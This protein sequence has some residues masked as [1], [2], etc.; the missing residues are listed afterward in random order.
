MKMNHRYILFLLAIIGLPLSI[1]ATAA[2]T[3]LTAITSEPMPVANLAWSNDGQTL[4]FQDRC[5]GYTGVTLAEQGWY[6]YDV[7]TQT[8][9]SGYNW[10][11]APQFTQSEITSAHI[12]NSFFNFAS[13]QGRYAAYSANLPDVEFPFY[14]YDRQENESVSLLYNYVARK[15]GTDWFNM[16]WSEDETAFVAK[17]ANYASYE[18]IADYYYVSNYDSALENAEFT[19]L[20]ETMIDEGK[21]WLDTIYDISPN[22]QYVL[23][24]GAE[25]EVVGGILLYYSPQ[26]PSMDNVI[27]KSEVSTTHIHTAQFLEGDNNRI[28]YFNEF[29]IFTYDKT[30]GVSELIRDDVK[31]T[32]YRDMVFSPGGKHL[33]LVKDGL[34][35][36]IDLTDDLPDTNQSPPATPASYAQSELTRITPELSYISIANLLWSTDGRT[37]VF[38]DSCCTTGEVT[39]SEQNWYS[40]DVLTDTLTASHTWYLK[41]QFT[42]GEMSSAKINDT[43]FNFVSPDGRY[44]AYSADMPQLNNPFHLYDRQADTSVLMPYDHIVNQS[45]TD[46]FNVWWSDN[47]SAFVARLSSNLSYE[48]Y[49]PHYHYV[50]NYNNIIVYVEF[51]RIYDTSINGDEYRLIRIYDIS[52]NGQYLL[53]GA[54]KIGDSGGRLL[55][56]EPN[57]PSATDVIPLS[58]VLVTNVYTAQFLQ[59]DNNRI[60]YLN[61]NGIYTYDRTTGV[62]ELIRDDVKSTDYRDMVF[63]PGGKH[64]ALV[65]DGLVYVV[66]L[67]DDLPDTNQSP[68]AT[69]AS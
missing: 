23:I 18:L 12:N 31:S 43:F 7:S 55:Y 22:G 69:P 1:G 63:S 60:I 52:P 38:Q 47:S 64:L 6:A 49:D 37:L 41:P 34:V 20:Y 44:V 3:A 27:P 42:A 9:S 4:V 21:Y 65:K 28:V 56:Y 40:Y 26:N 17:L 2:Q 35:Y 45:G 67:T 68:P 39:I 54:A 66:D 61:E 59:G 29:G 16:W 48:P 46:W 25:A 33:A 30:T 11:L 24:G 36:V 57:N 14:L 62:S 5:C 10:Q 53:I 32:D 8:L 13:P 50:S 15:A 19:W 58:E 51:I